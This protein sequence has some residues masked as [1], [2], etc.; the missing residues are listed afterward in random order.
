MRRRVET[1]ATTPYDRNAKALRARSL[2]LSLLRGRSTADRSYLRIRAP[3]GRSRAD[4]TQ[5]RSCRATD[6][7]HFGKH[8]GHVIPRWTWPSR[9]SF[10]PLPQKIARA[11]LRDREISPRHA[12]RDSHL[13]DPKSGPVAGPRITSSAHRELSYGRHG[14]TGPY[15]DTLTIY[16]ARERSRPPRHGHCTV[17]RIAMRTTARVNRCSPNGRRSARS[18]QLQARLPSVS[19]RDA[20]Q[21]HSRHGSSDT[22]APEPPEGTNNVSFILLQLSSSLSILRSSTFIKLNLDEL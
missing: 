6:V 8:T 20:S 10:L 19:E 15:D 5:C 2:S 3:R 18:P 12:T 22:E 1:T 11:R 16:R 21:P 7:H 14:K 9:D 4:G 17:P 13:G